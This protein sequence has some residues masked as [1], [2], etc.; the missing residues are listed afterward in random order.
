MQEYIIDGTCAMLEDVEPIDD[1]IND[2][3]RR[4]KWD[5]K[6]HHGPI[7]L[8]QWLLYSVLYH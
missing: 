3:K 7:E 1:G 2:T 8:L 6:I 5:Y 4:T